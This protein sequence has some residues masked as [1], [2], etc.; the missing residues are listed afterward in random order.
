MSNASYSLFSP[1][2][3]ILFLTLT[4][5]L[6][7]SLFICCHSPHPQS[8]S[9]KDILL[10]QFTPALLPSPTPSYFLSL[11]SRLP[12]GGA[13]MTHCQENYKSIKAE[14]LI[15]NCESESSCKRVLIRYGKTKAV[16]T[17]E[18]ALEF[19]LF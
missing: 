6:Y 9:V 14:S 11:S 17:L 19:N 8:T 2:K 7:T 13:E 3:E 10:W 16:F 1:K 12:G 18:S 5:F 4:V 15:W